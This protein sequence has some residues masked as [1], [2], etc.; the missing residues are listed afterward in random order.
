MARQGFEDIRRVHR[1]QFNR[2][3]RFRKLLVQTL[4]EILFRRQQLLAI[5]LISFQFSQWIVDLVRFCKQMSS[6]RMHLPKQDFMMDCFYFCTNNNNQE[7]LI[8]PDNPWG[9]EWCS[10]GALFQT[11][12]LNRPLLSQPFSLTHKAF[13]GNDRTG[14]EVWRSCM[15]GE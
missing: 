7:M 2:G 15:S 11:V 14:R 13:N 9:V 8:T 4:Y 1:F 10:N 5:Q 6:Q 12:F 3:K